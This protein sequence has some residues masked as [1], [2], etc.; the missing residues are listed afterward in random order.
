MILAYEIQRIARKLKRT[1]TAQ[2]MIADES[3]KGCHYCEL[4]LSLGKLFCHIAHRRGRAA[5]VEYRT[6]IIRLPAND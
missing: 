2:L 3:L 1:Y 4:P 5:P 6:T